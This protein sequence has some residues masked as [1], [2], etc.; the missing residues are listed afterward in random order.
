M[1]GSHQ[2]MIIVRVLTPFFYQLSIGV[3]FSVRPIDETLRI[4]LL[5]VGT[6]LI[7]SYRHS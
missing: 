4:E 1:P 3:P 6:I 2:S 5:K 7:M